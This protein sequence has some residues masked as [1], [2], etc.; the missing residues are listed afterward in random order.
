MVQF[1]RPEALGAG[2][3]FVHAKTGKPVF[4]TENG[5][6]TDNDAD[7]VWY[8]DQA[9]A[10]LHG[11]ISR[12]VPVMGYLHWSLLDNFEWTQGYKPKYGLV[13]VDRTSFRRTPKPSAAHLGAIARR[14][15]I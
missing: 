13:A 9:L 2:V 4:V 8:I 3:E 14:N 12:G 1:S 11:A 7:R 5:L 6:Q 15:A 10:S